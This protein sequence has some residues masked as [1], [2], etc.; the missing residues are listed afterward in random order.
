MVDDLGSILT[1]FTVPLRFTKPDSFPSSHPFSKGQQP[2][3]R[4]QRLTAYLEWHISK[5]Y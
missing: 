1:I 2:P 3:E 5:L 4:E